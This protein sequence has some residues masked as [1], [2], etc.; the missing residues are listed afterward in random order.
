MNKNDFLKHRIRKYLHKKNLKLMAEQYLP[1]HSV[2]FT[3]PKLFIKKGAILD[4]MN[5]CS[6]IE[7]NY[8]DILVKVDAW[9]G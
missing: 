4:E 2:Y 6:I 1:V 8:D 9:L 7:N 3:N 5:N